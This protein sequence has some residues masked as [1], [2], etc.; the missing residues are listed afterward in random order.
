MHHRKFTSRPDITPEPLRL[1]NG[2]D[3]YREAFQLV[4]QQIKFSVDRTGRIQIQIL[5]TLSA[6][7]GISTVL[8]ERS[9]TP[10][11]HM[12]SSILHGVRPRAAS[13]S[14]LRIPLTW[15]HNVKQSILK[16]DWRNNSSCLCEIQLFAAVAGK[17][18]NSGHTHTHT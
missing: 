8:H 6:N 3:A 10:R 13:L 16:M 18:T 1:L 5:R 7:S 2:S 17:A 11:G 15:N 14:R 12:R 9:D 4:H